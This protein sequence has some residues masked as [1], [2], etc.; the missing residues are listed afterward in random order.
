MR[1][2]PLKANHICPFILIFGHGNGC[3]YITHVDFV[4][5]FPNCPSIGEVTLIKF[6]IFLKFGSLSKRLFKQNESKYKALLP[7][8]CFPSNG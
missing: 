6:T 2:N 1:D 5:V 8:K 3:V 7:L 4:Q